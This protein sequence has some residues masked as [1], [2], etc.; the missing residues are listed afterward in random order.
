MSNSAFIRFMSERWYYLVVTVREIALDARI[1]MMN[2]YNSYT[3][4]VY[5]FLMFYPCYS[6]L[7]V[8]LLHSVSGLTNMNDR[9]FALLYKLIFN[10]HNFRLVLAVIVSMKLENIAMAPRVILSCLSWAVLMAK[11]SGEFP[12]CD[13]MLMMWG[14]VALYMFRISSHVVSLMLISNVMFALVLLK[15]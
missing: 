15:Y 13:G 11:R 5:L 10:L 12:N 6:F 3:T 2:N 1:G 9:L 7:L 4:L 14:F 8:D